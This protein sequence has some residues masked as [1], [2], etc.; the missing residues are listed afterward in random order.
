MID[1]D[2]KTDDQPN[3]KKVD[4]TI[5]SG[6]RLVHINLD[7]IDSMIK[8]YK[9]YRIITW[10]KIN[11]IVE[12]VQKQQNQNQNPPTTKRMK[13]DGGDNFQHNKAELT[14]IGTR[15]GI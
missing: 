14:A 11:K 7:K 13:Q 5:F 9:R 6:H 10:K 1:D 12:K 3:A 2:D 4:K 8:H 15:Q